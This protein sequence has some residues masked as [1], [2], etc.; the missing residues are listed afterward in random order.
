MDRTRLLDLSTVQERRYIVSVIAPGFYIFWAEWVPIYVL[1]VIG[2]CHSPL[3]PS[4]SVYC[5][6]CHDDHYWLARIT[7][8]REFPQSVALFT[9]TLHYVTMISGVIHITISGAIRITLHYATVITSH[10]AY[11]SLHV[12]YRCVWIHS[13][14][15]RLLYVK[16]HASE[17]HARTPLTGFI[18]SRVGGTS[19]MESRWP[20][21]YAWN[22]MGPY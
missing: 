15:G 5:G 18:S 10:G 19:P 13:A 4:N 3:C 1:T 20:R 22:V 21:R 16:M 8:H 9:F 17:N 12:Q 14:R 2:I 11:I 7:L 6:Y